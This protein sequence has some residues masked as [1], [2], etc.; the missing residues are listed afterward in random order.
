MSGQTGA[1][2]KP[3]VTDKLGGAVDRI[4]PLVN[5]VEQKARREAIKLAALSY[6]Q[7]PPHEA[8]RMAYNL[9]LRREPD[10]GAWTELTGA[11]NAGL[12]SHADVVDRV[13]CSNE[14]RT[15]V[16]VGPGNLHSSLHASRVEFII[17][18][19]PARRI[20]DLG[21]GHTSDSRGALVVLGYPYDFEEL[22]VVDLPPD[23]RHPLYHSEKYGAGESERGRVRYEYQSMA[24]LSFAEDGS[25]DLVYSG[26]SIE[27][28]TEADGD[29]VLREAFRI[30]RPGGYLAVDTP[31]GRVCRMQ[32]P[33]FIDPDHKVEYTLDELRTK[34]TR[35]GFEVQ[36]ERGLNW[37]GAAAARGEYDQAALAANHGIYFDVEN[38]YLLALLCRKPL[39]A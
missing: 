30:L 9:L 16:P 32:Q 24:D 14:Y 5:R 1:A 25:V 37:G 10:P 11:M 19:P 39:A 36:V 23:D 34:I 28:V 7:L 38:C 22:V 26:Q 13:R 31:N 12:L 35:V 27:H 8:V 6:T 3:N 15:Q 29:L 21:G 17:G 4:G 33:T 2:P 20:V 18:L